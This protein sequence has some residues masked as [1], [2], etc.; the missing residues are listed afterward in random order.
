MLLIGKKLK[1]LRKENKLTAK[2][3][4]EKLRLKNMQYSES[5]IY[6]WEEDK[7]EPDI[8][9]LTELSKIFK[10][11]LPS[12]LDAESLELHNLTP[13]E[14]K[15]LNYF[16]NDEDFMNIAMLMLKYIKDKA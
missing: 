13:R 8:Y 2:D 16:R 3:I 7:A 12:I 15:I 10:A 1:T 5:S 6:K 14:T 11:S 9:V 4:C